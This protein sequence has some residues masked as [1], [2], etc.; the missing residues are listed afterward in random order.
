MT[1]TSL[2]IPAMDTKKLA[3]MLLAW[4]DRHRRD[5][6]WRAHPG[7]TPDPYRVWLSEIMLQQTTVATV[8]PR[9][10]A[11]LARWPDVRALAAA[12][13]DDVLHE[14]QGLGYYARARNLH[15]C[16]RAIVAVHGG[17]FP[18]DEAMLRTLPGIGAYTA[19]AVAALAFDIPATPLDGN[20][21]R[22]VAR[23]F[24]VE[25]PLPGAKEQIR[26]LA[27]TLTPARRPGDYAQ[28]AMDLGA[29]IC[30]PLRP[31]CAL[32]PW[33]EPCRA[34]ARG[35]AEELPRQLPKKPKPQ[36]FGVVFWA[37]RKDGAVLLR[38]RPDKGLLGGMMEF[39]STP[40]REAKWSTPAI[41]AESPVTSE[42]APVPGLVRHG[43]THFDLALG[44]WI[45]KAPKTLPD[46]FVVTPPER[47]NTL[48][49]PTLMK[50]VAAHVRDAT[51]RLEPKA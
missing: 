22:V 41:I 18:A 7:E 31:A 47:F 10:G 2:L 46:G 1:P 13:L 51:S 4:Y 16:A 29:T 42:W 14:W 30:T 38:R 25:E 26:A 3:S 50:K 11:F 17:E 15:A 19:A 49:L 32:C 33:R 44:I 23:L 43:F 48:A 37:V 27:A 12:A 45:G 20:I 8:G 34:R 24:A 40:W 5:L 21:E 9:F 36:R 39:P 28:A 6:P 35:I